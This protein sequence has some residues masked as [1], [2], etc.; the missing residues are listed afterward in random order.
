MKTVILCGGKGLRIRDLSDIV[1]KPMIKIGK[2]PILHHIMNIYSKY[3]YNNFIL[4]LGYKSDVIIDYF[5][6]LKY[7][8]LQ[9]QSKDIFF[10][11]SK[12]TEKIII[13]KSISKWK[14][15]MAFTGLESNTGYRI[16]NIKKYIK[17]KLFFLTYGDGVGKINID[18]LLKFHLSHNKTVTL[19]SVR[20]PSRF[21]EIVS[22]NNQV[23]HFNEKPQVNEGRINGGF[24]ICNNEIFDY[25]KKNSDETCS[26]EHDILPKIAKDKQLMSYDHKDF[27]MP[28]DTN[29]EYETLN[30]LWKKNPKIFY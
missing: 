3:N 22:K 23:I 14:V 24:F 27:W 28:M 6:N 8:N 7:Q 13:P 11:Y 10:D 4:C 21:G 16:H 29:R 12:K 15:Q 18:K 9:Y 20:P 26:F 19:T 25:F 2:Y 30:K 1:P 5:K 17:D